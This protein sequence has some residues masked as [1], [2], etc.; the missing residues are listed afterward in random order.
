MPVPK[1]KSRQEAALEFL[2]KISRDTNDIAQEVVPEVLAPVPFDIPKIPTWRSDD[3]IT[4]ARPSTRQRK[5]LAKTSN[6]SSEISIS[7]PLIVYT[8]GGTLSMFS[9]LTSRELKVR[10]LKISK[11]SPLNPYLEKIGLA[12][13]IDTLKKK[14]T[15]ESYANLLEPRGT[16]L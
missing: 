13:A 3:D 9:L 2:A 14:R 1:I 8:F 12:T 4:D 15:A 10:K 6:Y 11:K 7:D 16:L 5:S